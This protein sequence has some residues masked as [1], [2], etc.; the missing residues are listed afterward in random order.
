MALFETDHPWFIRRLVDPDPYFRGQF[1][2]VEGRFSQKDPHVFQVPVLEDIG[3][4]GLHKYN[5]SS[6]L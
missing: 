1:A 3:D 4:G 5:S 2:Q 6:R